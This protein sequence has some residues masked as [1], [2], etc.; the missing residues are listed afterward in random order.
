MQLALL[1]ICAA[2]TFNM[3]TAVD[4]ASY[5]GAACMGE[6]L[7]ERDDPARDECVDISHYQEGSSLTIVDFAGETAVKIFSDSDCKEEVEEVLEDLCY[8]VKKDGVGSFKVVLG[9]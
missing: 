8:V 9:S 3:V 4:L 1:S 7:W 2:S 6:R 5:V